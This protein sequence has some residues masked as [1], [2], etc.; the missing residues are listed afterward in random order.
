MGIGLNVTP[1]WR[2]TPGSLGRRSGCGTS[3]TQRAASDPL[4]ARQNRRAC[5][6]CRPFTAAHPQGRRTGAQKPETQQVAR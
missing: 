1:G 3:V 6:L 2:K 5:L 4:G